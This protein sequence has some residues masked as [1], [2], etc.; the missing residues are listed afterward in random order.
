M[1]ILSKSLFAITLILNIL[2]C[3][4]LCIAYV[5]TKNITYIL[6][7]MNNAAIVIFVLL[8]RQNE[9]TIHEQRCRIRYLNQLEISRI[10]NEMRKENNND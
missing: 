4:S 5:V 9:K 8:L 1:K 2:S 7:S 6:L 10:I 3:I